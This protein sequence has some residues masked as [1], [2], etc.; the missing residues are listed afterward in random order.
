[1]QLEAG[2][3][4]FTRVGLTDVQIKASNGMKAEIV[5]NTMGDEYYIKNPLPR[6]AI[7]LL[8]RGHSRGG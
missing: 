4:G 2:M 3:T 7:G 1:M 5:A 8:H 6:T